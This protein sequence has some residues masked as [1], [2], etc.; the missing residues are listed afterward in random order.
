MRRWFRRWSDVV[1]PLSEAGW[2]LA[3]A[4]YRVVSSEVRHAGRKLV[5]ALVLL[6]FGLFALFWAIGAVAL[7]VVEVAS[8]WLPRW[9]AALVALGLFVLVGACLAAVARQR[10]RSIERPSQTVKRRLDKHREWWD[11]RI[12]STVSEGSVRTRSGEKTPSAA[13]EA[14]SP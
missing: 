1:G 6:A 11:H 13:D 14:G 8:L 7:V 12:A 5:E 9:G 2:D 4:E 3:R 10:L